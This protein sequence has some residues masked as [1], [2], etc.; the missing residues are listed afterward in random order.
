MEAGFAGLVRV[1][2]EY[3]RPYWRPTAL[4]FAGLAIEIAFWTVYPLAVQ[5]LIDNAATDRDYA[6]L[7]RTL[8]LL[9]G[10]FLA[11]A[12][13]L[14]VQGTLAARIATRL[15][16]DL[17]F[18]LLDHLQQ[19][20]SE[21]YQG[22][23]TGDL[24]TRFSTDATTVETAV[25]GAFPRMVYHAVR[26]AVML[27]VLFYLSWQLALVALAV[28]P[29][30]AI[31]P[32]AISPRSVEATYRRREREGGLAAFVQEVIA[33][34]HV[35]RAFGLRD[36]MQ[37]RFRTQLTAFGVVS[38][39]ASVLARLVRNS[40][41]IGTTLGQIAVIGVGGLLVFGGS[42]TAGALVGFIGVLLTIGASIEQLSEVLI[43][44]LPLGGAVRRLNDVLGVT[45]SIDELPDAVEA[46]RLSRAIELRGVTFGYDPAAPILRDVDLVIPAGEHVA[47]VG[48]S[49]SGKST[50]LGLVQRLHDPQ[51]G[52]VLLDGRDLRRVT[53]ESLRRQVGVVFQDTFL[54]S[55]SI[56]DNIRLG[57][58]GAG[59][60]EIA[61]A[62]RAAQIHD[63]IVGMPA[64]YD[65]DVG[66][67]GGRLSGGQR[68]RV[69]LARAI[70]RDPAVL[71]LD[72]ATSALD[73]ATEAAFNE[74][75]HDLAGQ[76]TL[77]SVTHRLAG[78]V[79]VD[80]IVVL[81]D[82]RVVE[83]G[84]HDELLAL[85]GEYRRLWE[86]Q[87]GFTVSGDGQRAEVDAARLRAIPL[88]HD[89]DDANRAQLA[90]LFVSESFDAGQTIIREGEVGDRFYVLVRGTVDAV[91]ATPDGGERLLRSMDDGSFFG[92]IA[93]LTDVPR[94]ATVRAKT[95]AL[96][97]SL[98]R[99]HFQRLLSTS[100]AVR[101]AVERA[102]QQRTAAEVAS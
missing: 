91:V 42:M 3:L 24:I 31:G 97:L 2:L 63:V 13:V 7:T 5:A 100:P 56:R 39:R 22:A 21:F 11:Y 44:W 29:V 47:L 33:G 51:A 90:G 59:D 26:V 38:Q 20:P 36:E 43:D 92:E 49:G 35:I 64:G 48:P 57:R 71:V 53:L 74:V 65:T 81:R 10:F 83:Q 32:R 28:M 84:R 77:L 6:A 23:Q 99:E 16:N 54:F 60:E 15:V 34:H 88:L 78:I 55:G 96:L 86:Q 61:A 8:G 45:P 70:I 37:T 89:I 93:L 46:P 101:A 9:V 98:A 14:V 76:R 80:R 73:P 62:A 52:A 102:A 58:P 75:L 12:A 72:E 25:T 67:R 4:L 85:D 87:Q 40:T 66:E 68:Q 18:K 1:S 17:R 94:T 27:V 30:A 95:P 82:G 50:I 69:A 19:L 41:A 79:G